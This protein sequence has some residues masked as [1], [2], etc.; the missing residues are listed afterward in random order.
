M[1]VRVCRSLG[2]RAGVSAVFGGRPRGS[3]RPAVGGLRL[4]T[5]AG[6]KHP[7]PGDGPDHALGTVGRFTKMT[8]LSVLIMVGVL[9]AAPR[10]SA[11]CRWFGTQ[12][13]CDLWGSRVVIGTQAAEEPTHAG[14]LP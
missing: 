6:P 5:A 7:H 9:A 11:A 12:V 2:T 14:S 1:G 4:A 3:A 10:A 13:E 8:R